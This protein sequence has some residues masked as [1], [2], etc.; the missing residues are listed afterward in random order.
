MRTQDALTASLG[1]V[2]LLTLAGNE[3]RCLIGVR[4]DLFADFAAR[5]NRHEHHLLVT[6][7]HDLAPEGIVGAG[8]LDD[9]QPTGLLGLH[10]SS[11]G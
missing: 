10:R 5:R 9:G 6:T 11:L 1:R 4:M 8:R 3:Q 7:G 2:G